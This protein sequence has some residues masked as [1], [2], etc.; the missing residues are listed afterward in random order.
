MTDDL[1]IEDLL[2]DAGAAGANGSVTSPVPL[3]RRR[4]GWIITGIVALLLIGT[5]GGYT[6]YALNA[7]LPEATAVTTTPAPRT[8]SA[9]ELA[10]P[11]SGDWAITVSGAE[12][13]FLSAATDPTQT[14]QASSGLDRVQP[15]ASISKVITALVVL[16]AKP[17]TD[18][19]DAGPTIT[20]SRADHALYDEY[21]VR[22]ATI[23]A[24]PTGS[25]MSQRDA[26]KMMLVIS[27]SNYADAV[28]RWAYGSQRAFLRAA[29]AWLTAHGLTDTTMVEPTGIDARNTST[30]ADMMLLGELAM[31]N[32]TIAAIVGSE[33]LNVSGFSGRN[34]NLLLGDDG[35]NGIK[36][37]T[38]NGSGSN[39]L[40][41]AR[42]PV[43]LGDPLE[44]TGVV[45][46]GSSREAVDRNVAGLLDSVSAGFHDVTLG[47]RGDQ[48]GGLSTAW[49]SH[50][51]IVLADD[52]SVFTWSDTPI[53]VTM[54][55]IAY[56]D[57]QA[58]EIVGTVTWTAGQNSTS[59]DLV[60]DADLEPPD[61]WWLLTNPGR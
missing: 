28:A 13:Y 24:M 58:D 61:T 50:A 29:D 22:N 53:E 9:V 8:P 41:S 19:N 23:A 46:G 43:G 14:L 18:A 40:F 10:A 26:L 11:R 59:V 15:M 42:L 54:S 2:K 1:Q 31:A 20:F 34:T 49:G 3:R 32:P 44:V 38:L 55:P 37:G 57:G 16:E 27:A 47:S 56:R 52:A 33:T 30:P 4:R 48:V 5:V 60:L 21:Y 36:T 39:L 6:A 35:V 25:R 51:K 17:L 7:P 45:L 12:E